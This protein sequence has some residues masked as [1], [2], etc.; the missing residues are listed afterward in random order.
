MRKMISEPWPEPLPLL[1]KP[2]LS[3]KIKDHAHDLPIRAVRALH[4][5]CHEPFCHEPFRAASWTASHKPV[6]WS[7]QF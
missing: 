7:V 1:L 6:N 2:V 4:G 5:A 3:S